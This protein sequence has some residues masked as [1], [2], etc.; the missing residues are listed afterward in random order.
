MAPLLA[1][2]GSRSSSLSVSSSQSVSSSTELCS[3]D[4]NRQR[5][6]KPANPKTRKPKTCR[7]CGESLSRD[8]NHTCENTGEASRLPSANASPH[9]GELSACAANPQSAPPPFDEDDDADDYIPPQFTKDAPRTPCLGKERFKCSAAMLPDYWKQVGGW[10]PSCMCE[11]YKLLEVPCHI[12]DLAKFLG[13]PYVA[14]Q[15]TVAV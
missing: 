13:V 7:K 2:Q 9:S 8:K 15:A 3:A 5:T 6:F 11:R 4:D 12:E 14:K 10:C 1:A